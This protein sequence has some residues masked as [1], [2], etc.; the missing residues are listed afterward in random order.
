MP[1]CCQKFCI[2]IAKKNGGDTVV[3]TILEE[4]CREAPQMIT[5][6]PHEDKKTTIRT[7]KTTIQE[8]EDKYVATL[9]GELDTAAAVAFVMV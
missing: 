1:I 9:E 6:A 4:H 5:L 7:M 3:S 2:S 8:L